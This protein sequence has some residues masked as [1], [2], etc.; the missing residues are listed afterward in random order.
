VAAGRAAWRERQPHLDQTQLVFIDETWATTNMARRYGRSPRGQRLVASVPH[1]HW[2]TSTFLAALR[3]DGLT[4]PCVIDGAINGATFRA[5]VEQFLA[6]TL[7]PG[8]LVVLDN[9]S[10]H[11]V[12]GVREA[13][14]ARGASLLYLPPYSP[15]LNPIEHAFAKFKQSLRKAAARTIDALWDAIAHAIRDFS[16]DECANFLAHAGY[17]PLNRNPL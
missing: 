2:K 3:H 13:I 10:S 14:E 17:V 16:S 4:A 9:L 15:D 12:A 1:G 8:D 7:K 11:K 5:Y 6:P